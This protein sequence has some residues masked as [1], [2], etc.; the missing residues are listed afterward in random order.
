[1]FK[2]IYEPKMMTPTCI[3]DSFLNWAIYSPVQNACMFSLGR[4]PSYPG[5]WLVF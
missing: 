1:M 5:F 4:L 2:T 3:L